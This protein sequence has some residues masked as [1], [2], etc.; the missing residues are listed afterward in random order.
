MKLFYLITAFVLFSCS[1]SGSNAV[2]P[3]DPTVTNVQFYPVQSGSNQSIA[4]KV[5]VSVPTPAAVSRLVLYRFNT[6]AE[7]FYIDNPTTGQHMLYDHVISSRVG[8]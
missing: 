2:D 4:F 3:N 5:T 6:Q 1:R 7:M 8:G